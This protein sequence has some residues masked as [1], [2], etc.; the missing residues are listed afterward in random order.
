MFPLDSRY[1]KHTRSA[2]VPQLKQPIKSYLYFVKIIK[3]IVQFDLPQSDIKEANATSPN[4]RAS[5]A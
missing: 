4:I 3:I 5:F 2:F 1:P